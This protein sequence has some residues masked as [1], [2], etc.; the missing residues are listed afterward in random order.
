MCWG[1]GVTR[2]CSTDE[3]FAPGRAE[4][5][6]VETHSDNGAS[7][8]VVRGELDMHT[9]PLLN[10]ALA[11]VPEARPVPRRHGGRDVHR[12]ERSPGARDRTTSAGGTPGA[13]VRLFKRISGTGR[14]LDIT[15]LGFLVDLQT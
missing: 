8:V 12:L 10:A 5:L 1:T 14:L 9:A 15:G 4:L 11:Q 7:T 6:R 2:D 3:A 13:L